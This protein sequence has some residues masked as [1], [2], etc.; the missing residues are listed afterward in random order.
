[1]VHIT[2]FQHIYALQP[3]KLQYSVLYYCLSTFLLDDTL[4]EH[5]WNPYRKTHLSHI[6]CANKDCSAVAYV[7]LK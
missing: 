7:I 3:L 5:V 2:L 6:S 1:M 4:Y